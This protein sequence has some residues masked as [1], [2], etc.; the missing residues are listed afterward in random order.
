MIIRSEQ[1]AHF[2]QALQARYYEQ[3]RKLLREKSPQLVSRLDDRALLESISVSVPRA[4]TYGIGTGRGILAYVGLA[5]AA[6]PAFHVDTKIRYFLELPG[7]DP[8]VKIRWL[9]KK[10]AESLQ[11]IPL[12]SDTSPS[13]TS[14]A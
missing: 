12:K 7:D 14:E 2:N 11:R 10:V 8:D 5:I 4:R 13:Q 3:I 6:G 9:F 1:L